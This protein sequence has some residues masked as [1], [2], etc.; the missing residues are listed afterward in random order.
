M[1][2]GVIHLLLTTLG[3]SAHPV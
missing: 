2:I 3:A 1:K